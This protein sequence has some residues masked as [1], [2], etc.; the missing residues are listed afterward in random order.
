MAIQKETTYNL[1]YAKTEYARSLTLG[2]RLVVPAYKL[3]SLGA[4]VDFAYVRPYETETENE[5]I[6]VF[7]I[8]EEP[9]PP[10]VPP[11]ADDPDA[12][13][14]ITFG[15]RAVLYTNNSHNGLYFALEAAVVMRDAQ[16]YTYTP[17]VGGQFAIGKSAFVQ[18]AGRHIFH[19]DYGDGIELTADEVRVGIG[20]RFGKR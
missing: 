8:H 5:T 15:P 17:E 2:F 14:A 16:G 1:A 12:A 9:L 10:T 13:D 7:F 20:A 4:A 6:P 3:L 19:E 18:V 11:T